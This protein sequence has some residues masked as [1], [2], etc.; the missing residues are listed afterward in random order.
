MKSSDKTL[1]SALEVLRRDIDSIDGVAN[2]V[3]YEAAERIKE[4]VH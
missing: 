2:A 1:V 3:V 4:R